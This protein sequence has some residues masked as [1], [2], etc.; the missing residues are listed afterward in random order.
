VFGGLWGAGVL[1][2][3]FNLFGARTTTVGENLD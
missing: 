1:Y 3:L 2:H